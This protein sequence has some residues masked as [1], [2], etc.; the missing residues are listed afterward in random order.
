M[1]MD[2]ILDRQQRRRNQRGEREEYSALT[3]PELNET[4]GA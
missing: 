2:T 4:N 3:I 1:C